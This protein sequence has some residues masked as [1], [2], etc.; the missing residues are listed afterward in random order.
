[1]SRARAQTCALENAGR[2]SGGG[3]QR[4]PPTQRAHRRAPASPFLGNRAAAGYC[5]KGTLFCLCWENQTRPKLA[6]SPVFTFDAPRPNP[7]P[8][9]RRGRG[10]NKMP[11]AGLEPARA[12]AHQILSLAPWTTR[13][14]WRRDPVCA[15]K[16]R[17]NMAKTLHYV[18]GALLLV[19]LISSASLWGVYAGIEKADS[20]PAKYN[21]SCYDAKLPGEQ[22]YTL[23]LSHLP[24]YLGDRSCEWFAE[25]P[26]RCK[27]PTTGNICFDDI[28]FKD[29]HRKTC[30]DW[31][32]FIN[33]AQKGVRGDGNDAR[34]NE[35]PQKKAGVAHYSTSNVSFISLYETNKMTEQ[36]LLEM[37]NACCICGAPR[38]MRNYQGSLSTPG[39]FPSVFVPRQH[40]NKP[41]THLTQ[42][43]VCIDPESGNNHVSTTKLRHRGGQWMCDSEESH[44]YNKGRPATKLYETGENFNE[45][46]TLREADERKDGLLASAIVLTL[47][48]CLSCCLVLCVNFPETLGH[49]DTGDS[50]LSAPF[51]TL[52]L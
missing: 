42:C 18:F 32:N 47:L 35:N 41:A 49:Q 34:C 10:A 25:D 7:A 52:I 44:R 13:A 50:R 16:T 51:S 24:Y 37:K 21:Q 4:R 5:S 22:T 1:M 39:K 12:D 19:L 46:L 11:P 43:C 8:K 23:R 38:D 14:Q 17:R 3:L 45:A 27:L 29:K 26:D 2:G 20:C 31:T 33:P 15:Y 40:R 48:F 36:E 9:P 28:R 6:S 30:E